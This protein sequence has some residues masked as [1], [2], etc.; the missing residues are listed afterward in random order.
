M[1]L[2]NV[3][4]INEDVH[5]VYRKVLSIKYISVRVH[6]YCCLCTFSCALV[7]ALRGVCSCF[8]FFVYT[9][10]S[11]RGPDVRI[12]LLVTPI[13]NQKALTNEETEETEKESNKQNQTAGGMR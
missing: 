13:I 8:M 5:T 2:F 3:M 9:Q 7:K 12:Y 4:A 6:F 1:L 10:R 11:C